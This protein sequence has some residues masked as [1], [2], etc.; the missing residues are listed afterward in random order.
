MTVMVREPSVGA[1]GPGLCGADSIRF[2]VTV[3]GLL[4]ASSG[5]KR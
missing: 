5:G 1:D 3:G 2:D 4:S